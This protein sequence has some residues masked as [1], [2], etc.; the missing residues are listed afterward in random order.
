MWLA[1]LRHGNLD[2]VNGN[3]DVYTGTVEDIDLNMENYNIS[4]LSEPARA[5]RSVSLSTHCAARARESARFAFLT[6][7]D[8]DRASSIKSF[9]NEH[10]PFLD[11]PEF[12]NAIAM[13]LETA[14]NKHRQHQ[15][16]KFDEHSI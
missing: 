5:K 12:P 11:F 15:L 4:Y 7:I 8:T 6:T 16:N 3:V 1:R 9:E 10:A 13:T 14:W 2:F